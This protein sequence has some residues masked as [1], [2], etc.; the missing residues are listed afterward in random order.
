MPDFAVSLPLREHFI[1][2]PARDISFNYDSRH[3]W[4]V[5]SDKGFRPAANERFR[6]LDSIKVNLHDKHEYTFSTKSDLVFPPSAC[7]TLPVNFGEGRIYVEDETPFLYV[8]LKF[9]P[10]S[11]LLPYIDSKE[12]DKIF[13]KKGYATKS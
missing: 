13:K 7:S 2:L 4:K 6:H 10:S 12:K 8:P 9:P 3:G 5:T 1:P 11:V